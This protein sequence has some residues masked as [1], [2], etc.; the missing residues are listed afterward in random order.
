MELIV[1]DRW[2]GSP[3]PLRRVDL[4]T[5]RY[6]DRRVGAGRWHRVA[7]HRLPP[8]GCEELLS[9]QRFASGA[10]PPRGACEVHTADL[11]LDF[12]AHAP[13]LTLDHV[14][15]DAT[16]WLDQ[17]AQGWDLDVEQL[18][19][20]FSGRAGIHITIP[21][22]TLGAWADVDLSRAYRDLAASWRSAWRLVTLDA[23]LD[24]ATQAALRRGDAAV[25]DAWAGALADGVTSSAAPSLPDRAAVVDWLTR[26]GQS[27]FGRR[28]LIRRTNSRRRDGRYKIPLRVSE[29]RRGPAYALAL[30]DRPRQAPRAPATVHARFDAWI[31]A[32][33]AAR[34]ARGADAPPA[35]DADASPL[36]SAAPVCIRRLAAGPWPRGTSNARLVQ[37]GA[38]LRAIGYAPAPAM[39]QIMPLA[40]RGVVD[41]QHAAERRQ[42]VVSVVRAVYA[43]AYAFGAPFLAPLGVLSDGCCR[44]C[45]WRARF[46]RCADAGRRLP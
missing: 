8:P 33:M 31:A 23:P 37:L 16:R 19:I 7:E 42:S 10:T 17:I 40:L 26:S 34:A 44:G 13:W 45:P 35:A 5:F 22:L 4:A 28:R 15:S 21:A 24:G 29:V 18:E 25:W 41:P 38:Y 1:I 12:D 27:M 43:G 46:P 9:M 11:V 32:W 30:A 36:W 6:R 39:A 14:W 3:Q 20:A 2:Q